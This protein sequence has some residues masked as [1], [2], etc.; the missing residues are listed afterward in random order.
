MIAGR[1]TWSLILA[2]LLAVATAGCQKPDLM[3]RKRV[4][5]PNRKFDAVLVEW[6]TPA[7]SDI[8]MGLILVEHGKKVS[9]DSPTRVAGSSLL[10]TSLGWV[11]NKT[12]E[13]RYPAASKIYSFENRWY[14][15]DTLKGTSD[16]FVE[17]VLIRD[18]R[19]GTA[20]SKTEQ[21]PLPSK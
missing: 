14:P 21:S 13:V 16:Q 5:S 2:L 18:V 10:D 11:D 17:I 19:S 6:P 4:A 9:N 8:V 15:S 3:E 7:M 20:N 12:V 1:L